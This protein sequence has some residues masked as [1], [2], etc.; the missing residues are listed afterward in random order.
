MDACLPQTGAVIPAH[1]PYTG[2][3]QLASSLQRLQGSPWMR[4]GQSL[5]W[6]QD[7]SE[8]QPLRATEAFPGGL[9]GQYAFCVNNVRFYCFLPVWL[10]SFPDWLTNQHLKIF[11]QPQASVSNRNFPAN[12]AADFILTESP[13]VWN[14]QIII[15]ATTVV[16]FYRTGNQSFQIPTGFGFWSSPG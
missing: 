9:N 10:Q 7:K 1:L 5:V 12:F 11:V 4:Q 13:S 2:P 14:F 8:R 15:L 16:F 3:V 6:G